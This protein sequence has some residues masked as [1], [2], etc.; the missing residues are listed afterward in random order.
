MR[1]QKLI[2]AIDVGSNS[3]HMIIAEIS[4]KS[5]SIVRK[6][7][8]V[9]RLGTWKE[10]EEKIISEAELDH[11]ASILKRFRVLS[12]S[13]NSKVRAVATSAVRDASNNHEFV[14]KIYS[15]TGIMINVISG[16]KEAELIFAGVKKALLI[17]KKDTLSLDIGGGSTEM[18]YY[19]G[20]KIV[21]AESFK[22]GAVRLTKKFF[23][24]AVLNHSSIAHCEEF[25]EEQFNE[26]RNI[27]FNIPFEIAAGSSGTIQN[28][29][30]I[31]H[32]GNQN[33]ILR[34]L[35]RFTFT[36]NDLNEVID[37]VLSCKTTKDRLRIGG[38]EGKRA[39]ILPAG[40]LILRKVFEL[41]NIRD[42]VISE[43]ALR[44]GI[45]LDAI[46][47]SQSQIQ[48]TF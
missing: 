4:G 5:F 20:G 34:K 45:I 32:F 6:E 36:S 33:K 17:G 29:A 30:S 44:E 31:I 25:I 2:S 48:F 46:K 9:I 1:R 35:N 28:A 14:D 41:F 24:G 38:I 22:L 3:F 37:F 8:E 7:R 21:F 27:K 12:D 42:M 47:K 26:D 10:G 11:A 19:A 18:V 23:P 13:Y 15:R 43:Y 40:L 39:D 16:R